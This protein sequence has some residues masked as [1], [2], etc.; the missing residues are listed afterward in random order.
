MVGRSQ[1]GSAGTLML[2]EMK[3]PPLVDTRLQ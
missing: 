1:I 3:V 2:L